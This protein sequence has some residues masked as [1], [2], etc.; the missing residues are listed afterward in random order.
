MDTAVNKMNRRQFIGS[1]GLS[2]GVALHLGSRVAEAQ[3]ATVSTQPVNSWLNIGSD[4]SISL[5]IGVTEMG[6][7]TFSTLGQV[8]RPS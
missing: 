5:S 2:I 6:Q 7:G 8:A 1:T 4:N 3:G